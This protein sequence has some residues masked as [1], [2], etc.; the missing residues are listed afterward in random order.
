MAQTPT[1]WNIERF[2][3]LIRSEGGFA[4]ADRS[5][6]GTLYGKCFVG[7]EAIDWM[8]AQGYTLNEALSMGQRLLELSLAHHVLD[9]HSFKNEKLFYRFYRDQ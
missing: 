5:Y 7:S 8:Q 2:Y 4:V 3:S 1:Q 9:E 6:M